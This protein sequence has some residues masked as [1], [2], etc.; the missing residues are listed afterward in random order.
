MTISNEGT[1]AHAPARGR[2]GRVPHIRLFSSVRA[3][4]IA[5]FAS[6]CV[7]FAVVA[8]LATWQETVYRSHLQELD[9]H[10]QEA[11]LLQESEAQAG[12]AALLLQRYVTVGD[13]NYVSEVR[14]H[15]AASQRA[16]VGA[17]ALGI[18]GD[19]DE[20][21][22]QGAALTV[23]AGSTAALRQSGDVE[24]ARAAMEAIVAPFR[25]FRLRLEDAT[26]QELEAV[27]SLRES[28]QAAGDR[29]FV[30]LVLSGA[31]GIVM[32]LA[33]SMLISRSI[34]KPLSALEATA[35]AASKGDLTAR[36]PATGPKELAHLGSVLNQMMAAVERSTGE[37]HSA[38]E[39][40]WARNQQLTHA[41][42][43]AASDALTGLWNHR[44]FHERIRELVL[45]AQENGA[46]VSLIMLDV[47]NF[48]QV[49]DSLGHQAGDQTLREIATA[50][51]DA[52][53]QEDAYRYGGDEFAILLPV[54]N[55]EKTAQIAEGLLHA[56]NGQT[57]HERVKVTVS[58]GVA[59]FPE[60]ASSAEDL[61]YKADM[62]LN[63]AKS[64]GKS[65]VGR[66][67]NQMGSGPAA[68]ASGSVP[69][70][71]QG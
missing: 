64:A 9:K 51:G 8:G 46:S 52:V 1:I 14:E 24:G 61:I 12:L 5:G 19:V 50:L 2:D 55:Q 4:I 56:I 23:A 39:E 67:Q 36:A 17:A 59:A 60:N 37:L 22:A 6:M 28:A 30:L 43:Q 71:R 53:G 66:W 38:Y 65:Q 16:L 34:L 7:V 42:A 33:V 10:S 3:R 45:G 27:S 62:A 13:E 25:E 18:R 58:L 41:R 69:A 32:A 70:Q 31:V 35:A 21:A 44:R 48:K 63:W 40:L 20:I 49:N 54:Y 68:A 47:D 11:T 26:A 15:A 57:D 29:A